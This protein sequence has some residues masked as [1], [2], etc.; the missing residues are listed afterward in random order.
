[1]TAVVAERRAGLERSR[2]AVVAETAHDDAP[3]SFL[4]RV[5]QWLGLPGWAGN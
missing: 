3:R 4:T 1:V 2:T 5:Q